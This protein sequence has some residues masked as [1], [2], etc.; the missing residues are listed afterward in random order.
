ME[1]LRFDP[2]RTTPGSMQ[3]VL[4]LLE[5][6]LAARWE[7]ELT[8]RLTAA[9]RAKQRCTAEARAYRLHRASARLRA[10]LHALQGLRAPLVP[11][12]TSEER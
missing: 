9:L 2:V 5:T 10:Q 12:V 8:T 11:P 1:L 7:Q 6:Q 3:G 4:T